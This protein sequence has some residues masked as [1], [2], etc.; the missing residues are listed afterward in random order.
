MD[1]FCCLDRLLTRV[2]QVAIFPFGFPFGCVPAV[3][4]ESCQVFAC[5]KRVVSS[6]PTFLEGAPTLGIHTY[7]FCIGKEFISHVILS[8][9][10]YTGH[11]ITL[12]LSVLLL[13]VFGHS[14]PLFGCLHVPPSSIQ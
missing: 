13:Q 12:L 8:F 2:R 10:A 14:V 6:L 4:P 11:A 3:P 5:C 7:S 9:L 1:N